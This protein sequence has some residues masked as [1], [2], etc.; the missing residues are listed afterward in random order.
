MGDRPHR[1]GRSLGKTSIWS[2]A[3]EALVLPGGGELYRV[4][5]GPG[6]QSYLGDHRVYGR[7]VVPGAFYVAVMISVAASRWPDHAVELSEVQF[8][9]A[10]WFDDA[11]SA[12]PMHI[13]V[14]DSR[15]GL[16]LVPNPYVN[17]I[18]S[19]LH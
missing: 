14:K 12:L 9:E 18:G 7:V 10:L 5:I 2:L 3:G 11:R 1:G 13:H 8:V 19:S 17:H 16:N 6:V 15:S 4:D